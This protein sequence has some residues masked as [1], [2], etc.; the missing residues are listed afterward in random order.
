MVGQVPIGAYAISGTKSNSVNGG[1]V[2]GCFGE[3]RLPD[4]EGHRGIY[5]P[6][7]LLFVIR[8]RFPLDAKILS[9]ASGGSVLG[10]PGAYLINESWTDAAGVTH[11]VNMTIN[12][13]D[14]SV[15][16]NA[17]KEKFAP[18]SVFNLI[19]DGNWNLHLEECKAPSSPPAGQGSSISAEEQLIIDQFKK[20]ISRP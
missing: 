9:S 2:I 10:N 19:Y 8:I 16:F 1:A 3:R 18:N 20:N 15:Q 4:I 6:T 5:G 11:A 14:Q 17:E 12:G 13:A 7:E